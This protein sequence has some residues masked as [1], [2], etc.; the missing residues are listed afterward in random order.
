MYGMLEITGEHMESETGFCVC[1]SEILYYSSTTSKSQVDCA[2]LSSTQRCSKNIKETAPLLF[3]LLL[4]P[5]QT[6]PGT[7][8]SIID[9][10]DRSASLQPL[11]KQVEGF[12]DAIYP[13]MQNAA[14]GVHL[15]CYSQGDS[16]ECHWVLMYVL[17]RC[18]LTFVTLGNNMKRV[19]K[20]M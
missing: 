9:L 3:S 5:L 4:L 2:V 12:K 14:D 19:T 20:M 1:T 8:V 18:I 15:I 16:S 10:F 13:I 11:W 17:R 7:N 6:H